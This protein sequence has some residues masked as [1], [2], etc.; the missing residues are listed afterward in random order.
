M[1]KPEHC[2][3]IDTEI[4]ELLRQEAISKTTNIPFGVSP[5]R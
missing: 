2:K 3:Y 1:L 5:A 4:L